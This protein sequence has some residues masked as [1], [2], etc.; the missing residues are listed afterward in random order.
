LSAT[1]ASWLLQK[2]EKPVPQLYRPRVEA[3][4]QGLKS[5]IFGTAASEVSR[6]YI[7]KTCDQLVVLRVAKYLLLFEH[8]GDTQILTCRAE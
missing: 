7:S 6:I 1:L 8:V 5:P 4:I 2:A 3:R